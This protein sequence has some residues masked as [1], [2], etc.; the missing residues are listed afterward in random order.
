V[1]SGTYYVVAPVG[2]SGIAFLGDAGE[3]V[4]LGAKRVSALADDGVVHATVELAAGDNA[5]TLHGFAPRPPTVTV[6]NGSADPPTYD[7]VTQR[8]H[9]VLHSASAD[10]SSVT[11]ALRLT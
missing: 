3:F 9:V 4:S 10:A 11:I 5:V 8:F 6:S 1:D 2:A 7:P